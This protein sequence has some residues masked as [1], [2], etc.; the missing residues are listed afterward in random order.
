MFVASPASKSREDLVMDQAVVVGSC[1]ASPARWQKALERAIAQGLEVFVVADTGERMV[2]S[3]SR[4]DVLHRS[5]GEMCT[6]AA[7]LAG[8]PVCCHRAAVR[9]VLG[10]LPDPGA[11]AV[12]DCRACCGC[13]AIYS[14]DG[15]WRCE[16][17]GGSGRVP[18]P[19]IIAPA[20][21]PERVAA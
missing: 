6:C 11:P 12:V 18:A 7:A 20:I 1:I 3:A 14:R 15:G 9:Y 19:R 17:C 8:D 2:T 13:G 4:L 10:W 16:A 21:V 5:D